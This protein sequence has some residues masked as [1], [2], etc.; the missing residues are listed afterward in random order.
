MRLIRFSMSAMVVFVLIFA[1]AF[2]SL[3]LVSELWASAVYTGTFALLFIATLGAIFQRGPARAFC[4]G[5]VLFGWGYLQISL[6]L[7][8]YYHIN[9]FAYQ[10]DIRPPLLTTKLLDYLYEKAAKTVPYGPGSSVQVVGRAGSFL[11]AKLLEAKDGKYKVQI[12]E[13]DP[14]SFEWVPASRIRVVDPQQYQYEGHSLFALLFACIGGLIAHSFATRA[15][16]RSDTAAA[17][18]VSDLER[19]PE[20]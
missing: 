16:Q 18:P 15:A 12:S 5:F 17:P 19:G 20:P 6:D 8:L 2:A 13:I 3:R 11:P 1:V 7:S 4:V 10:K 9:Q 14:N